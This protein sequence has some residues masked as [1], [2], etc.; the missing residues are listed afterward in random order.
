L[1]QTYITPFRGLAEYWSWLG[2]SSAA[3]ASSS[4]TMPR[5]QK[6]PARR[7]KLRQI[8]VGYLLQL[9]ELC[10]INDPTRMLSS[11]CR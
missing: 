6:P 9:R 3:V 5:P 8:G 7:Q 1:S 4:T 11:A 10:V 2:R